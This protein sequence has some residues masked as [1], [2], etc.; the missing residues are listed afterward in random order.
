MHDSVWV[1]LNDTEKAVLRAT[2]PEALD[3]LDED[4]LSELHDRVRRARNK[5]TRLYRR[6]AAE[7]VDSDAARGRAH[8]A[9]AR[10]LVKAEAFEERLDVVSQHLA[11]A[12]RASARELKAEERWKKDKA[13]GEKDV[14]AKIAAMKGSDRT[15]ARRI[16]AIVTESA[17]DLSPRTWYGMPAYA[18]D[19]KV[20]CFFQ[21]A[22]KFN[23]GIGPQGGRLGM[24]QSIVQG[25]E[26]EGS[27]PV[28]KLDVLH[29]GVRHHF[30][31]KQGGKLLEIVGAHAAAPS[32]EVESVVEVAP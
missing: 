19:G 4:E 21:D 18:K 11:K 6:R 22:A 23:E 10:T 27:G 5:Y 8:A 20:V 26:G 12:A 24:V 28:G 25:D 9:H 31:R 14:L 17:P 2:E 29:I 32:S 13:A 15:M 30:V 16:H 3:G 1:M 7:Q